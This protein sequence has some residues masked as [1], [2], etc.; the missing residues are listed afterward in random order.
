VLQAMDAGG[1]DG[2]IAHVSAGSTQGVLGTSFQS[3]TS[4]N[5]DDFLGESMMRRRRKGCRISSVALE[6][7]WSRRE[8]SYQN[9]RGRPV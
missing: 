6:V 8:E 9:K 1:K 5:C 2:A 7:F 4:L 3:A